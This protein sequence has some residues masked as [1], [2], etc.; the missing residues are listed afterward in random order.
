MTEF[1]SLLFINFFNHIIKL[2]YFNGCSQVKDSSLEFSFFFSLKTL[3]VWASFLCLK[4][5]GLS[6]SVALA[7][8]LDL[9]KLFF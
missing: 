3:A 9:L 2:T 7:T 1:S 5:F 6:R 4:Q 8:N